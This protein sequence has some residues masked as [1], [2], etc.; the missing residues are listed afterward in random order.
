[1]FVAVVVAVIGMIGLVFATDQFVRGASRVASGMSVSSVLV[2]AVILGCGVG[3]PELA[4]AF[5]GTRDSP[6]RTLL[7]LQQDN[8]SA[9][10]G[11][12]A[13]GVLLALVLTFPLLFPNRMKRHS[14]LIL[15]STVLFAVLLRGSLDRVEGI[16]MLLGF[17]IGL[18][19][20]IRRE[21][22]GEHDPFAPLIDD[23][24]N[25]KGFIETP[26][27]TPLQ[28]EM[29]RALCGLGATLV[30]AQLVARAAESITGALGY[31]DAVQGL[32]LVSLGSV[33][34]H[35]VVAIQALR[36]H[37][38]GL[39]VGNL[40]GSNLFHS[41]AVGGLVSIIK[42]YQHDGAF[43]PTTFLVVAATAT[44]TSLLLRSEDEMAKWQGAALVGGYLALTAITV[45]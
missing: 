42:P 44:I 23:E 5:H 18:A 12:L 21:D 10:W 41:L 25:D 30:A 1:M 8:G 31:S 32:V 45:P 27:M 28:L 29:T 35:V 3:L 13:A 17:V 33:L 11:L 36:L 19:I 34:P 24:Y 14:P 40:I 2:G 22:S 37:D 38:E 26:V 15:A 20:V 4:L 16:A 39:A 43:Q 6:L 9:G 7:G